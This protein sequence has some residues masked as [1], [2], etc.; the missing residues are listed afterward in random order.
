MS[1]NAGEGR[2]IDE[3]NT[4]L[5]N[6]SGHFAKNSKLNMADNS[7]GKPK[8]ERVWTET[9]LKFLALVLAD[10]KTEFAVR[11]ETLALK[12]SA[13]N[14]VF[15]EISKKFNEL[16]LSNE[17]KEENEREK[18]KSTSKRK[19][20]I[21]DTSPAKLRIKYKFLRTQWRKFTDRVKKGSGKSP[22][23][24]PEWFTILN[25]I[26]SDTMGSM[27][28]ASSPSDVLS[29]ESSASDEETSTKERVEDS[30]SVD[31]MSGAAGSSDSSGEK[32]RKPKK[33][34]LQVKPCAQKRV[35]SQSQAIQEMAKSFS[36]LGEV[37]QRRA[38][39][40]ADADKE[41]QAEFLRF[42]R[43]QAELNRQHELKMMEMMMKFTNPPNPAHYM[44]G[45]TQVAQQPTS[46]SY[47]ERTTGFNHLQPQL[48]S[49]LPQMTSPTGQLTDLDQYQST[50]G[51]NTWY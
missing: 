51:V 15:E 29:E 26:F 42:Q 40:M 50:S 49:D 20:T 39:M 12:K 22:K 45:P 17:F 5:H 9:E 4:S 33:A 1:I 23:T 48:Q 30:D 24:E 7:V 44:H 19:Y 6:A 31:E 34:F 36:A 2:T 8:K 47:Y 46:H 16:M 13:N 38:E 43:E 32:K 37:Q 18:S 25:P 10:E 3:I 21:L 11:L 14:E 35:K 28:T 27:D 41:R